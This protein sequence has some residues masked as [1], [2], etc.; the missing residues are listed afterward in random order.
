MWPGERLTPPSVSWLSYHL[1][2][3]CSVVR[4]RR[5]QRSTKYDCRSV[6][7]IC[8]PSS[9]AASHSSCKATAAAGCGLPRRRLLQSPGMCLL[10]SH[11]WLQ[12]VRCSIVLCGGWRHHATWE[13]GSRFLC[14]STLCSHNRARESHMRKR[15]SE[16]LAYKEQIP[17]QPHT[18]KRNHPHASCPRS[19]TLF[20]PGS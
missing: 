16:L 17:P 1:P 18:S 15:S 10:C 9:G 2:T 3:R 6:C 14:G 8:R 13:A 11:A 7:S 19:S 12:T 4:E 5:R 20:F